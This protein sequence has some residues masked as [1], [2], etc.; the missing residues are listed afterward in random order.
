MF[1]GRRA[2]PPSVKPGLCSSS[3]RRLRPRRLLFQVFAFRLSSLKKRSEEHT[4][5]LQSRSDLVCRLLLEKKKKNITTKFAEIDKAKG[6][7]NR[8]MIRWHCTLEQQRTGWS[9]TN[10]SERVQTVSA[11]LVTSPLSGV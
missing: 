6:H 9:A 4:S 8:Y 7:I 10:I 2:G 1:F 3:G 5:E 11:S